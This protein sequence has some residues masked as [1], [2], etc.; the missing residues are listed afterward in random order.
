MQIKNAQKPI[1]Q[2]LR[3]F[4]IYNKQITGIEPTYYMSIYSIIAVLAEIR[5]AFRVAY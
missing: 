1:Q 3:I 5:V 2:V 4:H